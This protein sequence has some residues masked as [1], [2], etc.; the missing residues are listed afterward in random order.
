MRTFHLTL[1]ISEAEKR[2]MRRGDKILLSGTLFTARDQVHAKLV[3][4]IRTGEPNPLPFSES[5]LFYCG[6]SPNPQG[7]VS[8]A[9]GP[10]TS[11]RMDKYTK[12][13][14]EHGLKV[15]IGKGQR[16]PEIENAIKEFGALYLVC[17]GGISAILTR[18]VVSRETF[19]WPELDSEAIY[20]LV[21]KELPCYVAIV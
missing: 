4:L 20:R 14:L 15:I 11:M 2:E 17:V 9:I 10:T 8:G 1:P 6:P 3:E 19:L 18:C 5:A 21:V 12:A 16:S 7:K 13:L